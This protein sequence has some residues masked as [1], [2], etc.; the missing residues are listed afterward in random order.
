MRSKL[1]A[2]ATIAVVSLPIAAYA[3]GTFEGARRGAEEGYKDAGPIGGAVGAGVGAA[4]GTVNGILGIEAKPRFREHV[5]HEHRGQSYRYSEEPRVGMV[6]PVYGLTYYQV[7]AE[8]HMP[9]VYRY[10]YVNDQVVIVDS[11]TRRIVQ[12]VD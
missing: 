11:R 5:I 4:V 3:Q 2:I 9:R 7:P 12:V 8:Y 10:A 1:L 6:L